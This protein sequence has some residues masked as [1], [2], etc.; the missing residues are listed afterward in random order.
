[1]YSSRV[2]KKS[3]LVIGDRDEPTRGERSPCHLV[4]YKK[5][6]K[7]EKRAGTSPR[8]KWEGAEAALFLFGQERAGF[9]SRLLSSTL[10]KDNHYP[11]FF[12]QPRSR[13]KKVVSFLLL[14]PLRPRQKVHFGKRK[15]DCFPT[16]GKKGCPSPSL[17]SPPKKEEKGVFY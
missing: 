15:G 14:L 16:K 8:K 12:H 5:K 17:P 10:Q 1:M 13:E 3:P 11:S 7:G 9:Y 4:A 6:K 2:Q